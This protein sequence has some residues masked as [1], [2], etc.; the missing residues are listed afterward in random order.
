[1]EFRGFTYVNLQEQRIDEYLAL[2]FVKNQGFVYHDT[3]RSPLSG[4][5]IGFEFVEKRCGDCRSIGGVM[6]QPDFW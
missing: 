2:V 4:T 5:P 3:L 6:E 1:C